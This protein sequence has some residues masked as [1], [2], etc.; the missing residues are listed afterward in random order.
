MAGSCFILVHT[1]KRASWDDATASCRRLGGLLAS[2]SHS[3][4]WLYLLRIFR[5]NDSR[6]FDILIGLKSS[7]NGYPLMYWCSLLWIKFVFTTIELCSFANHRRHRSFSAVFNPR[8]KM[9]VTYFAFDSNGKAV[10][11]NKDK[12]QIMMLMMRFRTMIMITKSRDTFNH[13]V[14]LFQ[15]LRKVLILLS[16]TNALRQLEYH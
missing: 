11:D 12:D 10:A 15:R 4:T 3:D 7:P 14:Y 6:Q 1:D 13:F 8:Q 16:V 2:L 5:F 9:D